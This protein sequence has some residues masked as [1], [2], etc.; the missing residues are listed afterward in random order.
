MAVLR[1]KKGESEEK[2]GGSR[3]PPVVEAEEETVR[4]EAAAVD[5]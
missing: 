1:S 5:V 2:V 4:G 3:A